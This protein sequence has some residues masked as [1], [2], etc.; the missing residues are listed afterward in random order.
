MPEKFSIRGKDN[1]PNA[2]TD[3]D[4]IAQIIDDLING[5]EGRTLS[6]KLTVGTD[7]YR[8]A[9]T[10]E[11]GRTGQNILLELQQSG[12]GVKLSGTYSIVPGRRQINI[13]V[14]SS[15]LTGMAK[16]LATI[17]QS[18]KTVI[19]KGLTDGTIALELKPVTK[20]TIGFSTYQTVTQEH[21]K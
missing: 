3:A 12:G 1:N 4:R 9:M 11:M 10:F 5:P 18:T 15:Q 20:F 14:V 8:T 13:N 21:F 16:T 17:K 2:V 6:I 7:K 19:I